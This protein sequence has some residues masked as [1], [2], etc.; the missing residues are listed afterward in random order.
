MTESPVTIREIMPKTGIDRRAARCL[1]DA[2]CASL[3]AKDV[4]DELRL[5]EDQEEK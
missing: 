3:T 4:M 1:D 5:M 2:H